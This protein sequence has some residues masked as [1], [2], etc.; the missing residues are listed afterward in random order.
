[1]TGLDVGLTVA[2]IRTTDDRFGQPDGVPI[3]RGG[4]N[5]IP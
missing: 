5:A 4:K 1:M 2:P 3:D